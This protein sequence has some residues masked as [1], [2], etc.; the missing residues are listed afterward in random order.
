MD[1]TTM[2]RTLRRGWP[3]AWSPALRFFWLAVL[4][5]AA[6]LNCLE[7][8][9]AALGAFRRALHQLGA[10]QLELRQFGAIALAPAQA[11]D[12]C[13][14]AVALPEPGAQLVEQLFHRSR[15]PQE[16]SGLTARMQGVVLG[17]GDH[18]IHQGPHGFGL[19]N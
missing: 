18:L 14:A 3:S 7:A 11:H 17:Q 9:F 8:L 1:A 6:F 4:V 10:Y 2:Q 13:I 5:L 19:G 16:S 12:A 15:R